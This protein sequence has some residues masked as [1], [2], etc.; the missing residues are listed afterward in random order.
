[1]FSASGLRVCTGSHTAPARNSPIIA[2]R[3]SATFGL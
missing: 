1:M 2:T 3:V